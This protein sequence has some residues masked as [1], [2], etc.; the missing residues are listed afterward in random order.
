MRY[1]DSN[2]ERRSLEMN[3]DFEIEQFD[4]AE[5]GTSIWLKILWVVVIV[6]VGFFGFKHWK[7]R[8]N[9]KRK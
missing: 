6:V 5:N 7:K 3:F 8:K 2:G 1:S 4:S 9:K